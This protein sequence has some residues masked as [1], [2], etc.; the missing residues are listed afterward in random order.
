MGFLFTNPICLFLCMQCVDSLL[1]YL[2]L[3]SSFFI[4]LGCTSLLPSRHLIM[5]ELNK[6]MS[7]AKPCYATRFQ[8]IQLMQGNEWKVR[9]TKPDQK[10]KQASDQAAS[11]VS[12][13]KKPTR[14]I[15]HHIYMPYL[16]IHTY[17]LGALPYLIYHTPCPYIN[18]SISIDV[19]TLATPPGPW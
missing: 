2:A 5:N 1:M 12:I 16:P 15:P 13:W 10:K 11:T 7:K 4:F 3:F 18:P 9:T 17:R 14:I 6:S 8:C 19:Q